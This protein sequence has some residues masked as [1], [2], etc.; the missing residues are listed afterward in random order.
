LRRLE[1]KPAWVVYSF[2]EYMEPDL[3]D[4][5]RR[6][7]TAPHVFPGTLGGGDVVVCKLEGRAAASPATGGPIEASAVTDR[8]PSA[9][10]HA[11]R[12]IRREL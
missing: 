12:P 10:R 5:I 3:V 2:P 6:H 8:A 1:T 4:T 7:C 9:A 11:R